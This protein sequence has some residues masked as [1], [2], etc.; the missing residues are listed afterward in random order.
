MKPFRVL[1]IEDIPETRQQLVLLYL[2]VFP[3]AVVDSAEH[4][5]DALTLIGRARDAHL[6]YDIAVLDFKLPSAAGFNADV[7]LR[8]CPEILSWTPNTPI[9]HITAFPEDPTIR[10]HLEVEHPAHRPR[11]F[12]VDKQK[13]DWATKLIED[14]RQLLYTARVEGEYDE[15]FGVSPRVPRTGSL[16]ARLAELCADVSVA[17]KFLG[18]RVRDKLRLKLGVDDA[19]PAHVRV[20]LK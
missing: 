10:E 9:A 11:G 19:D 17:W 2:E 15:L 6:P 7:D 13:S 1:I 20:N 5:E 3:G 16:S 14:S 8:L 18:T 12:L 4:V